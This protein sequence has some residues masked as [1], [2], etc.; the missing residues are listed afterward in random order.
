LNIFTA[1]PRT[2]IEAPSSS[3]GAPNASVENTNSI[4]AADGGYASG[5]PSADA[6]TLS[7][8]VPE[9]IQQSYDAEGG[10][11]Y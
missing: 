5:R 6:P 9:T 7:S 4:Y 8:S 1:Q 2:E 11:Q 3:Y 10:Y